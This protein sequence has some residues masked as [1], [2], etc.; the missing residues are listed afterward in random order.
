MR[1]TLFLTFSLMFIF[2]IKCVFAEGYKINIELPYAARQ[3][4]QLTYHYLDKIYACDTILLDTNG[5][6]IFQGDS[7]LTQGLYM[8]M[9]NQNQHFDFLLGA[10]QQFSIYNN[11][12]QSQTMKVEGAEETE[13][14]VDYLTF[15]EGLKAK[16]K[17][18]SEEFKSATPEEKEQIKEER[19]ALDGNMKAYWETVGKNLPG[20]FLY[21]F[22]T[23]NEVPLLDISTLPEE[24]Q[25]NDSLLLLAR[26]NYQREHFWDNFD[27]TDERMLYTPF[28][29]PKLETWFNKVLFPAYDSVK[30]Y[31]YDFLDQVESNPRIFQF[32]A[33]FFINSSI[34]SNVMGMDALFVDLA[35]DYYLN[36][37]AFWATE[38]SLD[39]IRENVLFMKDNLIGKTAPD[40]MMESYD[41][42]FISL[43]QT[44]AKVTVVL[45][46]EPHCGH[47]KVFVPEFH[48]EIYSRFKDKGLEVYAIYSM[49]NK[50]EWTEFL[51]DHD[52]FDW[53]NVWDPE[54]TTRFKIRYDARI[55]PG[56][57]VLDENKKIIAKKVTVEQLLAIMNERFN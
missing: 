25:Q 48:D 45:I 37:K 12:A 52:L 44:E 29:K 16:S 40:L 36:G 31:V 15:L 47:C 30:P 56:V 6:G 49:D 9:I 17:Q 8:I 42:E 5:A 7:L 34:N 39:K 10:D 20:S 35:N 54:N 57:Y 2:S 41:G 46:F 1:R 14:F 21:K 28:F 32:A 33:S 19:K 11:S 3:E 53:I 23:A 13:A 18:L 43:H 50:E 24:I 27:Y 4:I 22:L 51:I 38:N 26:F 55:T